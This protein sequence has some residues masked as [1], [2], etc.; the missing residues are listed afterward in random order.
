[1]EA[2]QLVKKEKTGIVEYYYKGQLVHRSVEVR[3][4]G[5]TGSGIAKL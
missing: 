3:L 4:T 1:M 5:V 2:D